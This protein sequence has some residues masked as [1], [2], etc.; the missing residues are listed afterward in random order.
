MACKSEQRLTQDAFAQCS[1]CSGSFASMSEMC[2]IVDRAVQKACI[3]DS[4]L[5]HANLFF[6]T[7]IWVR[8]LRKKKN[9]HPSYWCTILFILFTALSLCYCI[10]VWC[11]E[12]VMGWLW[13]TTSRKH[14]SS[15]W[16]HQSYTAP[17]NPIRGSLAPHAKH[18]SPQEVSSSP[19]IATYCRGPRLTP[20]TL[21]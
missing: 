6:L 7:A 3:S 17:L 12:I 2:W 8:H 1:V 18:D 14:C 11:L 15:T 5:L 16:A 19:S 20:L 10:S 4:K 13:W 21:K 9:K